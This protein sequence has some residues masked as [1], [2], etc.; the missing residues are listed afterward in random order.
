MGRENSNSFILPLAAMI[1]M[2]LGL[3]QA[4]TPV[5]GDNI[6][7]EGITDFDNFIRFLEN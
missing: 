3:G 7:A 6:T 4:R 1:C 2:D 5:A